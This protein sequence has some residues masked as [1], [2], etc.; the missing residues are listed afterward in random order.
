MFKFVLKKQV[1][2]LRSMTTQMRLLW[3]LNLT[4]N[5]PTVPELQAP[6]RVT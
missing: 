4:A 1:L 3:A 5:P 6:H 2:Q